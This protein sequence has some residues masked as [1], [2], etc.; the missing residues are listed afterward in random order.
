[1]AGLKIPIFLRLKLFKP[2][3]AFMALM[4]HLSDVLFLNDSNNW[5][6]RKCK[7]GGKSRYQMKC[8]F[9]NDMGLDSLNRSIL[10]FFVILRHS[11]F[12]QVYLLRLAASSSIVILAITTLIQLFFASSIGFIR[13][14]ER[15]SNRP[16]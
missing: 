16:S 6:M 8:Q 14:S 10:I 13:S 11:N 5:L 15:R 4:A 3:V 2:S 12:G 9:E 1:M 7:L